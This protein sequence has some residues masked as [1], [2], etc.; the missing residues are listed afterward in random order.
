MYALKPVFDLD[1]R[2]ELPTCM[3]S[4][5]VLQVSKGIH[6]VCESGDIPS[7]VL[8]AL[9]QRQE[10]I[11]AKLGHL[12]EE[13]SK[14][15]SSIGLAGSSTQSQD[16]VVSDIVVR[17][18]PSH[19]PFSLPAI[20]SILAQKM[21]VFTSVH[22]HSCVTSLP[23]H[24][25]SF[26]PEPQGERGQADIKITLIWKDVGG[27]CEL[28]V[29]PVI[30]SVIRGEVNL[31]RY[32]A[33]AFPSMFLYERDNRSGAI[34]NI[35]D[36]VTSLLWA[37]PK[38]RQPILRP[39]AVILGKSSHLLGEELSIA[40]LA[41]F[42]AIKQLGLDKDLQSELRKWFTLVSTKLMGGKGRRTSR[43]S[44]SRKSFTKRRNSE[45]KN[46]DKTPEKSAPKEK[47]AKKKDA[48]P[49]KKII[50]SAGKENSP[51]KTVTM[52]VHMGKVELFDYLTANGIPYIN[53]AH[54]AVM[55]VEEMIPHVLGGVDGAFCK[56]LFLKDKKENYYLLSAE[57]D[58]AVNL[59]AVAKIVGAKELRF[60][61]EVVM[62]N[63]L[64]VKAGCV[65]PFA[66]IND[67]SHAVTFLVDT[68][69]VDGSHAYVNFHP[70]VNTATTNISAKDFSKF[71]YLTKTKVITF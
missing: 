18:S 53:I 46:T 34:D 57:H 48:P 28:M 33:R 43:R 1:A 38:D 24:L 56:N 45:R 3:Y 51:P 67:K 68:K 55:T 36:S 64:G 2:V 32:F 71:L 30:Q 39:L 41:L 19:P 10:A 31:L 27:Q 58:R 23:A 44:S 61:D 7:N 40:D 70:L 47:S 52:A 11:L 21:K 14:Y 22:C 63:R 16:K 65:T 50:K 29:S 60:A 17:C 20:V 5:P 59:A 25:S 37:T 35:L 69:L 13:V 12:S 6:P 54:P 4:L 26:L 8:A 62:F 49:P 42:S 9:E 66:L 15:R